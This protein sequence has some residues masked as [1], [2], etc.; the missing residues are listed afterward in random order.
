MHEKRFFEL[1]NFKAN[2][3]VFQKNTNASLRNLETQVRQ[4]AL[5]LQ[6]QSRN[7]FPSSIEINP[8]DFTSTFV[9]GNNELQGN[10]KMQN[11]TYIGKKLRKN[12]SD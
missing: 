12:G 3:I 8:K 2:T 11:E 10:K 6:S 9:S 4:L 7:A 5:F 1:E